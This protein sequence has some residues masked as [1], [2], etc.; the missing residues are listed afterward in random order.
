MKR[1]FITLLILTAGLIVPES[2]LAQ[3]RYKIGV[4]DWMVLKR[5]KLGEPR[6]RAY[7]AP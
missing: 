5:Q 6:L 7:N 1:F 4:C 3:Q 2:I